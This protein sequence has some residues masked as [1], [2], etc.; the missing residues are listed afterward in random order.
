MIGRTDVNN[1]IYDTGGRNNQVAGFKSPTEPAA[2]M[3]KAINGAVGGAEVNGIA[4]DC[5]GGANLPFGF[6]LPYFL[7]AEGIEGVE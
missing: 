3:I 2:P 7:A 4:P 5:W 1:A 6:V